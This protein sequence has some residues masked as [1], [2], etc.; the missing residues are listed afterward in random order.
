MIERHLTTKQ[1]ADLMACSTDTIYRMAQE[2]EIPSVYWRGERRY[3]ISGIE[4][5]LAR[6]AQKAT[7]PTADVIELKRKNP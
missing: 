5:Y 3:P 2:G 6:T 7:P 1:L 4:R